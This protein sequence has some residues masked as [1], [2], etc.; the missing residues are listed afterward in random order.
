MPRRDIL[1]RVEPSQRMAKHNPQ[2]R[3]MKKNFSRFSPPPVTPKDERCHCAGQKP[4]VLMNALGYNPI[5][6]VN[7]NLERDPSSF[8]WGPE[9]LDEIVRWNTRYGS[10]FRLWLDSGAYEDWA[11]GQ[12]ADLQ[13]AANA[14][15]R[16]IVK[17]ITT[18][19]PCYYRLFQD[20]EAEKARPT[21][22][23]PACGKKLTRV[24][25]K[26]PQLACEDCRL[27]AYDY[28]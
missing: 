3:P 22:T 6:C 26:F 19:A 25:S 11:S 8:D 9:I 5:A 28:R 10:I 20:A 23:C 18:A 1:R 2:E 27:I 21:R 17:K 13:S 15:G 4:T 12:L 7:C 16:V 14:T 24:V